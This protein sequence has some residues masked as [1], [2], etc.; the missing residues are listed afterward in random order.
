MSRMVIAG[1]LTV[2]L[3]IIILAFPEKIENFTGY[4]FFGSTPWQNTEEPSIRSINDDISNLTLY[5]EI[6]TDDENSKI[7][8]LIEK[9]IMKTDG[10]LLSNNFPPVKKQQELQAAVSVIQ[11][12]IVTQEMMGETSEEDYVE[13]KN[14]LKEVVHDVVSAESVEVIPVEGKILVPEEEVFGM[15]TVAG[16]DSE[17][18]TFILSLFV[19]QLNKISKCTFSLLE[20]GNITLKLGGT[21]QNVR[22]DYTLPIYIYEKQFHYTKRLILHAEIIQHPE[23]RGT[24]F[25]KKIDLPTDVAPDTKPLL[26][27]AVETDEPIN[28]IIDSNGFFKIKN[29]LGLFTPYLTSYN[30][31]TVTKKDIVIEEARREQNKQLRSKYTCFGVADSFKISSKDECYSFGGVWDREVAEDAEC[32]MFQSNSNYVNNRGGERNGYCEFPSGLQQKGYRF[33]ETN[34]DI[35]APLCYNCKTSLIGQGTLGRC[36]A[37]QMDKRLYPNLNSPDYKFPGDLLDRQ[38]NEDELLKLGM[39]IY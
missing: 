10:K 29:S 11:Q 39:S 36:C 30:D 13:Q 8:K 4:A 32:P 19:Q 9:I 12:A 26:P 15:K 2:V 22:K 16:I 3:L 37:N 14:L 23:E 5:N 6:R 27:A 28:T 35:S 17:E 1:I 38:H 25:I 33:Y 24:V 31:V 34:P 18:V 7:N 20:K 21:E